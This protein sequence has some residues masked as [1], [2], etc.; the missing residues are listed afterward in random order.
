MKSLLIACCLLPAISFADCQKECETRADQIVS[1]CY[2]AYKFCSQKVSKLEVCGDFY[3]NC[4]GEAYSETREC[5]AECEEMEE[6][7][8]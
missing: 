4:T 3:A 5:I 6:S 7:A 2:N 8:E 1:G